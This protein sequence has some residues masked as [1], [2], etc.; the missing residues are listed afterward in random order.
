M[1][2]IVSVLLTVLIFLFVFL[3]FLPSLVSAEEV[4]DIKPKEINEVIYIIFTPS[5]GFIML[6]GEISK[7]LFY[8]TEEEECICVEDKKEVKFTKN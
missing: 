3:A 8:S 4:E 1:K 6:S 7:A 5:K 2:T